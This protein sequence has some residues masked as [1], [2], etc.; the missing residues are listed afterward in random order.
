MSGRTCIGFALATLELQVL[1]VRLVQRATWTLDR[2]TARG[3]GL[4]T[5]APKG[6][7]PITVG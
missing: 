5:F 7:V 3:A 1:V 4:A 2:P 6:G